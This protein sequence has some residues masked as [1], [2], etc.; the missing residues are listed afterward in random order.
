MKQNK[1][2]SC[3]CSEDGGRK[4]DKILPSQNLPHAS[5]IP[6]TNSQ[7]FSNCT[8]TL[9]KNQSGYERQK[10]FLSSGSLLE[11][12]QLGL[13]QAEATARTSI[14][15]AGTQL[16]VPPSLSPRE[17]VSKK[18]ELEA[19]PRLQSRHCDMQSGVLPA[20]TRCLLQ[21]TNFLVGERREQ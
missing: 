10:D 9:F 4:Y 13:G 15:V 18:L 14:W 20:C 1:G 11:L 17:G 5:I 16:L 3:Q 2:Q 21:V 19:E 7:L 12:L 8:F 6:S